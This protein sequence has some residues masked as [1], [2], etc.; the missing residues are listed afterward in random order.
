MHDFC[1]FMHSFIW[2]GTKSFHLLF[3]TQGNFFGR[4]DESF[5]SR[6]MYFESKN[7]IKS[8]NIKVSCASLPHGM[9][10]SILPRVV[11]NFV[12]N[13]KASL[14]LSALSLCLWQIWPFWK[15]IIF[16]SEPPR[17]YGDDKFDFHDY[18]TIQCPKTT[19]KEQQPR[20][21]APQLINSRHLHEPDE[22]KKSVAFKSPSG[23]THLPLPVS[24]PNLLGAVL[25]TDFIS[26]G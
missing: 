4:S 12:Q 26:L 25:R 19:S 11:Q 7:P 6:K 2:Q 1:I 9:N 10:E 22:A 15:A 14:F 24:F 17:I 5:W 16:F 21:Q 23:A 8:W 18:E 20:P 3:Y 13:E